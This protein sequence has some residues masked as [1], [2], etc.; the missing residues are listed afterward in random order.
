[1]KIKSFVAAVI[2]MLAFA[3][4]AQ[5]AGVFEH[6]DEHLNQLQRREAQLEQNF[7]QPSA[8]ISRVHKGPRGPKGARGPQGPKGDPEAAGPKGTFG[9]I[10]S[11]TSPP[12]FLCSIE[13]GACAVGS[14]SVSCP[15][16][17]TLVGGGYTGAGILTTVTYDAPG[18]ANSWGVIGVNFDE[19][20]VANFRAVAQCASP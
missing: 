10:S 15:P 11:V 7:V 1:M 17:T 5:A 9:S 18:G 2:G 4:I 14:A 6:K 13:T 16:G 19:V 3:G 8:G 12:A 20:P